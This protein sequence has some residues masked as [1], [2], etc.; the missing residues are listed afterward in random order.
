MYHPTTR[1]LTVL[2]LLQ[3]YGQMS[4]PE[5]AARLEVD[6]RTVRRYVTMLQ[7]LGVPVVGE[8]G[9]YGA[10]RLRPG[11]KLPPLMFSEDEALA[12]VIGLLTIRRSRWA[13]TPVDVESALA[14]VERV[15]PLALQERVRAVQEAV[16]LDVGAEGDPPVSE[17]VG[18]LSEAV[19]RRRRIRM[20]Y[21]SERGEETEREVDPYRVICRQGRWYVAGY[22]HLRQEL[23]IFR[24]DRV[25]DAELCAETFEPPAEFDVQ[26]HVERA[27]ATIPRTWSVEVLLETTMETVRRRVPPV[28]GTLE[29]TPSGVLLRCEADDLSRAAHFLAGLGCRFTILRPPELHDELARLAIH[30][31]QLANGVHNPSPPS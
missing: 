27:L 9:R 10:Y 31:A 14:K 28:A 5:L 13:A 18:T 16:V 3:A 21:R 17:V 20:R 24:V 26:E 15:M 19:R 23:R 22:C 1:V 12:L 11:Y 8:R 29:Q 6:G 7:D 30:V 2:E 25:V 4:G